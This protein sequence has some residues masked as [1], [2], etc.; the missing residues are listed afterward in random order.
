MPNKI[1]ITPDNRESE[2]FVIEPGRQITLHAMGMQECDQVIVE[3]LALTRA[4]PGGDWCCYTGA[5][6]AD[7][8]EAIPLRCRTPRTVSTS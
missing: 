8:T 1:I 2:P 4:G 5:P 7:I 6:Q 3:V